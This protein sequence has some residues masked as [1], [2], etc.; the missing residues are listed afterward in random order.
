MFQISREAFCG[1]AAV[2]L[3]QSL[4]SNADLLD[5]DIKMKAEDVMS[6]VE[7]KMA[8][9]EKQ[10]K[11]FM[12]SETKQLKSMLFGDGD[13]EVAA[14]EPVNATAA[15]TASVKDDTQKS[16]AT[17]ETAVAVKEPE[18]VEDS[19]DEDEDD[20]DDDIV[21][22]E[23]PF[24]SPGMFA[25]LF[26]SQIPSMFNLMHSTR[27]WW[28]GKN[29]CVSRQEKN[30][31]KDEAEIGS[32]PEPV[33]MMGVS[34]FTSCKQTPSKYVCTTVVTEPGFSKTNTVTYQCCHGYRRT[35][36]NQTCVKVEEKPV[37][38]VLTD[39]GALM[40]DALVRKT[41]L[42]EK[43]DAQNMTVFVPTDEAISV[44]RQSDD[45]TVDRIPD[46]PIQVMMNDD[47]S[48]TNEIP[49]TD[50][51]LGIRNKPMSNKD[52]ILAQTTPGFIELADFTNEKVLTSEFNSTLRLNVYPGR[53]GPVVTVNCAL[54]TSPDNYATNSIMHMV[55]RVN[56][57]V[58]QNLAQLL[59]NAEFSEFKAL[60]VNNGLYDRLSEEGPFTVF[61]PTNSAIYKLDDGLRA[62]YSR[63]EACIK[64][65]LKHHILGHTVCSSAANNGSRI[66]TVNLANDWLHIHMDESGNIVL[67]DKARIVEK[68]MVATNG[69]LHGLDKMLNP[70]NAKPVSDLLASTNHSKWLELMERAG[71]IEELNNA[72]NLTMFAPSE[73]ALNKSADALNAMDEAALRDVIMYHATKQS[74][75]IQNNE[76]L[77]SFL[78]SAKLRVHTYTNIP[79]FSRL[80]S[81][82][83]VECARIVKKEGKACNS[84]VY[85]IDQ[86]LLPPNGT[87]LQVIQN[88][89][90]LT[91]VKEMLKGTI[92]E[93]Q[94][95][96]LSD[97]NYTFL[98]PSNAAL[99]K[100]PE[101]TRTM[102]L[103]VTGF[104]DQVLQRHVIFDVICCSGVMPVPWPFSKTVESMGGKV[105][106]VNRDRNDR[107]TFSGNRVT[108]CDRLATDGIVHHV[109]TVFITRDA[110][111]EELGGEKE[112][113]SSVI[114]SHDG[115]EIRLYGV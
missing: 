60:L 70:K 82:V 4:A 1:F 89:P 91:I 40:F 29:V 16:N 97:K 45:I 19:D 44:F 10:A 105:L 79:L 8:E 85:E 96:S 20:D 99:M 65:V 48:L 93:S 52:M 106:E 49:R 31:T 87:V 57:S 66:S 64:T 23:F 111:P 80:G 69:V 12:M 30:E 100:L 13:S 90:E 46:N 102:L 83:T 22:E 114:F 28:Q 68:D 94:L 33:I 54:I 47:P 73:A 17:V 81:S 71:V 63:G 51:Q 98:A 84:G 7:E 6:S 62:K 112:M 88:D 39:M 11:D 76:V 34:Q 35:F 37:T 18:N 110:L 55:D 72:E 41:G 67:D 9:L 95:K 86:V 103:Q 15:T 107:V 5:G 104:A 24:I 74:C 43:L 78:P 25:N 56:P 113:S 32:G 77:E 101:R 26:G 2:I 36:K 38:D 21:A 109:D 108:T 3:L 58:N 14:S 59:E 42:D 75:G 53:K 115:Q 61:A 92:L 27:P 50:R